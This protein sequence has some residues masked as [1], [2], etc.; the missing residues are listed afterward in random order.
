MRT[1]PRLYFG[2]SASPAFCQVAFVSGLL[3][4]SCSEW[5]RPVAKPSVSF[6]KIPPYASGSSGTLEAIEGRAPGA[7][8]GQRIVLYARSGE[9][10][11]QPF[12]ASPFT[13]IQS[14]FSWKSSTHPG[15]A[16]AAV[17]VDDK[18]QPTP[19]IDVLPERS[20]HVAAVTKVE[21][22][23]ATEEAAAKKLVFGGYQW[24]VS[25]HLA[26]V[27]GTENNFSPSNV[28]TDHGGLLHLQISGS[29]QHWS[30]AQISLPRSLGYGSYR[31]V[32]RDLSHM[33]P[34]AAFTMMILDDTG[35]SREMDIEISRW[36]ETAAKNGQ[37]VIQPYHIPANTVQF[38][39]P[40]AP[41]TFM[42]RWTPRR[43]AFKAFRGVT[44]N[45]DA[46][47]FREHVFTSG[48]PLPGSESVRM[49]LYVFGH[50]KNPLQHKSEI[51]V[52]AFE[53]L[54]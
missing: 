11:V 41:A 47:A 16:Y 46:S 4:L 14:D 22:S 13:T 7:R 28:W 35:P 34:S 36:G 40:T 21:N 37:F 26:A 23:S 45:W 31:F 27:A 38:Q 1:T 39:T 19:T 54:P 25:Q 52:E 44:S 24:Q 49:S 10:W 33:E 2:R 3:F 42:L 18:F 12:T 48:V 43:A 51:V 9:W 50:N 32:V 17:L 5:S 8:A 30:S 53:Y 15:S 29:P 20:N 6:T